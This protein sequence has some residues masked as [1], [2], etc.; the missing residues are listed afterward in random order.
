MLQL[1]RRYPMMSELRPLFAK[2]ATRFLGWL[3]QPQS[4]PELAKVRVAL[5][6][7]F[8]KDFRT[9]RMIWL[10]GGLWYYKL[11]VWVTLWGGGRR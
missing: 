7:D 3:T 4:E 11:S 2:S 9:Q 10:F 1:E 6:C 5:F 8:A